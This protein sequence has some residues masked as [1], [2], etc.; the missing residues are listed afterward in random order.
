MDLELANAVVLVTGGSKGIGL[1]CARAFAGE[2]ARLAIASR[3]PA[4]LA[5]ATA[6]LKSDGI[7]A[8]T[9]EADLADPTQ[10]ARM[11]RE[12]EQ[13][14]GPIDVLVNSAGAAKRTPASELTAAHWHAA[15]QAKFFTYIHAI[16]AVLPGMAGRRAGAI[17]NIVG[18]GGKLASPVHLPGGSAN[19]ALMLASSGL[20]N[21]YAAQGVRVNV[22]NPGMTATERMQ[23]GL[24]AEARLA[25]R[26]VEEVLQQRLRTTPMGRI[27]EP[28]DI[29]DV[30]VFLASPRAGYVSGAVVSLDG[31]ATPMVV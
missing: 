6:A 26:P 31:A 3:D 25:G 20:A 30:V 28:R 27:A 8:V 9:V 14:L 19:A 18:M 4:N 12:V 16:D 1:A 2:G 22:V 29:A 13:Q 15:M 5:A 21:A 11:V 7:A 17:V 24:A 10:A 23:E